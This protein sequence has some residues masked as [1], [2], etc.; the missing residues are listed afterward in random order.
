MAASNVGA[1]GVTYN[2]YNAKEYWTEDMLWAVDIMTI[3]EKG[4]QLKV[5]SEQGS[6]LLAVDRKGNEQ[7]L[8]MIKQRVC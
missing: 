1:A 7:V 3:C 5:W 8:S 2:D 4:K 6:S